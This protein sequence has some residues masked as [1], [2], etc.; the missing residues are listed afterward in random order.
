ML[1]IEQDL[2]PENP[3]EDDNLGIMVCFHKRYNLGDKHDLNPKDFNGWSE[4]EQHLYDKEDAKIVLPLYLYDH[5]GLS[6]STQTFYGRL[7]Q[8]HAR[9]DSG[10]VGFIYAKD[11]EDLSIEQIKKTLTEEVKTYDKY[12]RGE[13]YGYTLYELKTCNLG[14]E[15][16]EMIDSCWGFYDIDDIFDLLDWL[17]PVEIEHER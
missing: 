17:R 1:E 3:R 5:S 6:M 2:N 16:K 14:H 7:P 10:Q 8:G 15:H 11:D 13:V 12:L 4:L 9:F